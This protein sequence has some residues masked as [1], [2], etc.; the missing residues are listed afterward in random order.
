MFLYFIHREEPYRDKILSYGDI[1]FEQFCVLYNIG[2]LHSYL[3]AMDNRQ[4]AEVSH[5]L[6]NKKILFL[7]P[8]L[9]KVRIHSLE[10][11]LLGSS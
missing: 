6:G 9:L 11:T 7:K 4:N 8:V 1:A 2:A 5:L 3:G 10:L